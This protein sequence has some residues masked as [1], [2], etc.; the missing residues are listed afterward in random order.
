MIYFTSDTHYNHAKI[1][2]YSKRPFNDLDEMREKLINNWNAIVMPED[3]I[4]HLG[5]FA[6]GQNCLDTMENIMHRLNGH[7]HLVP[8][9][10]DPCHPAHYRSKVEKGE[11]AKQRFLDAGFESINL[12]HEIIIAGNLVKMCHMPYMGDHTDR[13]RYE[14]YRP[15]NE[16]L[17]L[18]HGHTHGLWRKKDKMIDVGVDANNYAPI[19]IDEIAKLM[20]E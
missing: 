8:G 14:E 20:V 7:K 18:L 12:E 5:D 3:T 19:S 9:N 11:L 15:K 13:E 16:G 17:W 4:Y 6:M 1:I 10:H 2:E